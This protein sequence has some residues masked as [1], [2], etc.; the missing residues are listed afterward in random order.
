MCIYLQLVQNDLEPRTKFLLEGFISLENWISVFFIWTQEI[1]ENLFNSIYYLI[2]PKG[3][4]SIL[5]K[6]KNKSIFDKLK[7]K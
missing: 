2:L 6:V 1:F 7:K 5:K 4:E 3:W